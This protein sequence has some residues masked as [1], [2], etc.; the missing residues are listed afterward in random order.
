MLSTC[1]AT[2]DPNLFLSD[3]AH[4]GTGN[5]AYTQVVRYLMHTNPFIRIL[6]LTA[7][8]ANN[9]EKA[10]EIIDCLHISRIEMRKEDSLDIRRHL[11]QKVSRCTSHLTFKTTHGVT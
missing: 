7:T 9:L 6:A 5:Y 10:Q 8:P 4:R 3:E 1:Q 11:H 2:P